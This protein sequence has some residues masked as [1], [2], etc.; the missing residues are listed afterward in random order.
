ML[1]RHVLE[2]QVALH[3]KHCGLK[4][5]VKKVRENEMFYNVMY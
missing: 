4:K 5:Y 3:F 1:L 2:K